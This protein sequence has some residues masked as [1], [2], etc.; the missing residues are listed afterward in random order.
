MRNIQK[1]TALEKYILKGLASSNG[2]G[3][4][5]IYIFHHE[6][7]KLNY[8]QIRESG[9]K[10]QI[11]RLD[12]AVTK[13]IKEILSLKEQLKDRLEENEKLILDV[14]KTILEDVY[15]I[16]E[17]KETIKVQ[18]LYAEN[19]VHISFNN[20]IKEIDDSNNEYVKQRVYD[21]NDL[22]LRLIKNVVGGRE[23]VFEKVCLKHI[24]A[25]KELTSTLAAA[26]GKKRVKGILAEEGGTY[27]SHAAIILRGLGIPLINGVSFSSIQKFEKMKA[28][29]SGQEGILI[30][31]PESNEIEQYRNIL[32][33]DIKEQK[34]LLAISRKSNIT[35]D[36]H[37]IKILANVGNIEECI[38][39][40]NKN[41]DGIGLVRTE[42]LFAA[43]ISLPDEKEQFSVYLKIVK[44]MSNK[45]IVFRTMDFGGDK[46]PQFSH[47]KIVKTK[48]E[49]RG[50]RLSLLYKEDFIIQL[51]SLLQ[52][53]EYGNVSISFP[54]VY[55][56][57]EVKEAKTIIQ[58]ITLELEKTTGKASKKLIVGAFIET[59]E[60]I[61]NLDAILKEVSFINIGTNDLFQQTMDSDRL[62]LNSFG[63]EYL[64]PEFLK[65]IKLC[66]SKAG[67]K[68]KQI[69][70]C[71]E[72]ATD[73]LAAVLLIGMGASELSLSPSKTDEIR[74][75]LARIS[76]IE[77]KKLYEIAIS[78]SSA[79]EVKKIVT[80]CIMK[81][82][83]EKNV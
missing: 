50:I 25:V 83:S 65:I 58:N 48:T 2:V 5:L 52:V 73:P 55:N 43:N 67:K 15:F 3:I 75:T 22:K 82:G 6:D 44:K 59:R 19:A 78:C 17:I 79:I 24:V 53:A 54:M 69:V 38:L 26:L 80:E 7:Y 81:V 41:V 62:S 57:E 71:G 61:E 29:V 27:F 1:A 47:S 40:K 34:Q 13:T 76:I 64:E 23:P 16:N 10:Y 32:K 30:V 46:I 21:L 60:A 74:E 35:T 77:A 72:M 9:I 37:I 68:R 42:I 56:A 4:G 49:L 12:T 28:I 36:G 20:C 45:P 14:Y 33:K 66:I 51:R 70:I 11:T 63:Y 39:A 31:N 18:R 8:S